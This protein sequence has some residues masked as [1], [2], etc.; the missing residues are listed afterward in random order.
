MQASG[1]TR[2]NASELEVPRRFSSPLVKV[3]ESARVQVYIDLTVIDDEVME[4]LRGLSVEIEI[5]DEEL[6]IVQGWLPFDHVEALANDEFVRRIRPPAY[7]VPQTGSI[8][9]E[10]DAILR[11]AEAR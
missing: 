8:T 10:G 7:G 5:V 1:V 4:T 9:T 2:E 11:A 3:D 6:R